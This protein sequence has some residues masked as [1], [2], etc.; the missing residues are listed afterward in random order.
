MQ[1]YETSKNELF[2]FDKIKDITKLYIFKRCYWWYFMFCLSL[3][4][5]PEVLVQ[6]WSV[7]QH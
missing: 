5:L 4:A 1:H 7:V 2:R 6:C 3:S